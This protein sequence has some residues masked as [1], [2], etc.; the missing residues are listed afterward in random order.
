MVRGA[1]LGAGGEG[2]ADGAGSRGETAESA[3][4]VEDLAGMARG[5]AGRALRGGEDLGAGIMGST[6]GTGRGGDASTTVIEEGM[7]GG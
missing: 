4:R 6:A 7:S 5:A 3:G 1:R 2:K